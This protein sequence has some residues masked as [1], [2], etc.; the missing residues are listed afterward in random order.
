[1]LTFDGLDDADVVAGVVGELVVEVEE[2]D[3]DED[4]DRDGDRAWQGA[5]ADPRRRPCSR[6][7]LLTSGM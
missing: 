4:G 3:E 1:M 6:Q 7:L 5:G 2:A